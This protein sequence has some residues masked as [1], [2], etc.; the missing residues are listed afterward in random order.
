MDATVEV[1]EPES[2]GFSMLA[3]FPNLFVAFVFH[4]NVFPIYITL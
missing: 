3:A 2:F 1:L 4:Y